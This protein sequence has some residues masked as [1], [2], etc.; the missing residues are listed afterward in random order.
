[1]GDL[2]GYQ[3]ILENDLNQ[4]LELVTTHKPK[5]LECA[6]ASIREGD[7]SEVD[8]FLEKL[9]DKKGNIEH[10]LKLARFRAKGYKSLFP[11]NSF[12]K[13]QEF[14]QKAGKAIEEI[15]ALLDGDKGREA[16]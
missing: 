4:G 10:G 9:E 11:Q 8:E 2:S 15:S 14:V 7:G 16:T 1:M 6:R 13:A 12:A 3:K 5:I